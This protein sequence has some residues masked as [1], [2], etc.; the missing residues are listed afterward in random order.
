MRRLS[1]AALALSAVGIAVLV[2]HGAALD[3]LAYLLPLL[4]LLLTLG[5]RRYPGEHVLLAAIARR[6][7][8]RAASRR[9]SRVRRPSPR[10]VMPRGGLLIAFA[11]AVRP[12]PAGELLSASQ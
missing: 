1:A 9:R 6:S 10:T 3:G 12:P 11:L 5:L 2:H 8:R 4:L 7:R